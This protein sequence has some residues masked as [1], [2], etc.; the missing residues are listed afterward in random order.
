MESS[1]SRIKKVRRAKEK[2]SKLFEHR[3]I[4]LLIHYSCESFV[5]NTKG[6]HK[7]T[8]IAVR[9]LDSAQTHSFSIFQVSEELREK[10]IDGNFEKIE[11]KLLE[12]LFIFMERHKE[13][14][15]VHWN[16]RDINYGFSALEHR[17]RALGGI[18][19]VLADEVKFDLPR[20][21]HER[22][23]KS[24]APHPRLQSLVEMNEITEK[25]FLNGEQ[26]GEAFKKGDYLRLHQSTLRKVDAFDGILGRIE[27]NDL[28]VASSF[29]EIYGLSP[30]GIIKTIKE[31]WF[32]S[33]LAVISIVVGAC[34]KLDALLHLFIE[35]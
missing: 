27:E 1:L 18:P 26:E 9:N 33:F 28:K 14:L 23:G 12:N 17:L 10:D 35:K 21:L 2:L 13:Y 8:S 29:F 32:I 3:R 16:M 15:W 24:Y 34:L 20:I 31:H 5:E 25:D 6:S 11:K 22:Y 30:E 7:V 19:F 4:V